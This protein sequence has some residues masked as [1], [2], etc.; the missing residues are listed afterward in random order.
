VVTPIDDGRCVLE[1]G[2]DTVDSLAVHLG[3]L[4]FDFEVKDPPELVAHLRGLAARYHRA[5]AR[6]TTGGTH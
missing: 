2:A 3:L 1:T 6:A 5:T 4:G